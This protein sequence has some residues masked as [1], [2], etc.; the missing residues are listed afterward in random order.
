MGLGKTLQGLAF[1]TW[2][3]QGMDTGA[4]PSEPMLVVAPTGLLANWQKEHAEHLSA[5]GLGQCLPAFGAGLRQ[6]RHSEIAGRQTLDISALRNAAWVLTT[7][8]TLRDYD[9]DFGQVRFA[10]AIFDEA[11][12]IKTPG[13][14]LTDAA[15]DMNIGFRIALTGTPVENRLSDL[16]CIIDTTNPG[17]LSDLKTFSREYEENEHPDRLV[18]LRTKLD[19]AIGNRPP[20]M[21]R[22][23]RRDHLPDLPI[24]EERLD[25]RAMPTAQTAA[26]AEAIADAR[27][28]GCGGVLAA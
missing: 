14:R 25:E 4:V 15:K 2:L 19:S 26:Y 18:R 16:W 5:P 1:L 21:L 11:Q 12:K 27:A 22:R 10:A 28:G 6:L 24:M 8:E 17:Y 13:I 3:R 9:R 23:L 7:Y 20:V